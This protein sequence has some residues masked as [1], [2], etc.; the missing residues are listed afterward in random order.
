MPLQRL[1]RVLDTDYRL[2][3]VS[4][5]AL[6]TVIVGVGA[7][8]ALPDRL[9]HACCTIPQR[10]TFVVRVIGSRIAAVPD[11]CRD[12]SRKHHHRSR[13]R[14]Q[15]QEKAMTSNPGSTR[16]RTSSM[17]EPREEISVQTILKT[18]GGE[19][20]TGTLG[21]FHPALTYRQNTD[22]FSAMLPGFGT[23]SRSLEFMI[24]PSI[25][26]QVLPL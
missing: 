26:C 7:D 10:S 24:L 19:F 16:D 21:K 20:S 12:P 13:P 23:A 15:I 9:H 25:S 14:C 3:I 5:D 6:R 4:N 17:N 8:P 11:S 22:S 1:R 2:S 18:W